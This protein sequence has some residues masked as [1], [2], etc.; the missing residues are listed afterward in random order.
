M[1]DD[2]V[3]T[4]WK[5]NET[6]VLDETEDEDGVA[7]HPEDFGVAKASESTSEHEIHII[8]NKDGVAD[9]GTA[10]NLELTTV[11]LNDENSGGTVDEGKE[12]IEMKMAQVKN[13]SAGDTVFSSV[14]GMQTKQLGDLRGDKLKTPNIPTGEVTHG[15]GGQVLPGT[16]Y[17][18]VSALD[19]TGE[20]VASPESAAVQLTALN[21]QIVQDGDSESLS[22]TGNNKISYKI[23]GVGDYI[24]GVQLLQTTGGT[25]VGNLR[26]ETDNA[27]DP[28]GTLVS[29]NSEKLNIT[30]N[31][32]VKT[33][34]FFNNEIT[35]ED[36][37]TYHLVFSITSGTGTLKG[38]ATG[39]VYNVKYYDGSWNNSS[40]IYDLYCI[41]LGD[42][43]INW[44]WDEV[45]NVQT[46]KLFRT[47]ITG[48]YGTDSLIAEGI[49]D[50]EYLDKICE[51]TEGEPL[52]VETVTY[53]HK[54]IVIIKIV[55]NSL[56][57]K[58]DADFKFEARW[59]KT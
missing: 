58:C 7:L 32:G 38:K 4:F 9:L 42:N 50:N 28:S 35:W 49:E 27:G 46:Q 5:V 59:D 52:A 15:S 39:T 12:I 16:Y 29:V 43:E 24:N 13:E 31:D 41:L 37:V 18:A 26:L 30:L 8:N 10:Y 25:L 20:T 1:A 3:I 45:E 22:S 34:I 56:A 36:G 55:V 33:S 51:P 44:T 2:P 23:E 6:T 57:E 53:E 17:A 11:N 40:N 19:E 21:E 48:V 47:E 54:V 14:G